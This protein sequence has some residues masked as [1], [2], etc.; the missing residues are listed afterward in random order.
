MERPPSRGPA[1]TGMGTQMRWNRQHSRDRLRWARI[2]HGR[3]DFMTNRVRFAPSPTGPCT[4]A[5]LA[6][7]R[8]PARRLGCCSGSTTPIPSGTWRW[9]GAAVADLE[10]LG[11]VWNDGPVGR[12]TGSIAISRPRRALG[13]RFRMESRSSRGWTATYHSRASSMT[14]TTDHAR[15]PRLRSPVERALHRRLTIA[16]HDRPRTS[17]TASCSG[18]TGRSSRSGITASRRWQTCASRIPP[19]AVRPTSRSWISAT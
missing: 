9:R 7:V 19:A 2:A 14:S 13:E 16:R 3:L 12:A 8:P 17:I 4:S 11:I 15:D 6:A 18:R 5:V 10:W 1:S